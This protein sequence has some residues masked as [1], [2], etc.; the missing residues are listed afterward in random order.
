MLIF[1]STT[2]ALA[3]SCDPSIQSR[4][5]SQHAVRAGARVCHT[6]VLAP[7]VRVAGHAAH[8]LFSLHAG[9]DSLGSGLDDSSLSLAQSSQFI[10]LSSRHWPLHA[11]CRQRLGL[12]RHRRHQKR[13]LS[14]D[15]AQPLQHL[16]SFARHVGSPVRGSRGSAETSETVSQPLRIP[17]AVVLRITRHVLAQVALLLAQIPLHI[18]VH[19]GEEVL[20]RGPRDLLSV[21]ERVDRIAARRLAS[22]ILHLGIP[23]ALGGDVAAEAND[24]RACLPVRAFRVPAFLGG[25][26]HA[27]LGVVIAG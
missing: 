11:I 22:L 6:Q 3:S 25:G 26:L 16:S 21:I 12:S 23:P 17:L 27:V 5:G 1:N 2:L 24:G 19:I 7:V 4:V 13:C 9:R 14:L 10:L 15:A 20:G 18:R 8:S